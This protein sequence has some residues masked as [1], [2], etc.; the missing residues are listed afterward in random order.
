MHDSL[1]DREV[2]KKILAQE[3]ERVRQALEGKI[4]SMQR[5]ELKAELVS[6]YMLY[7]ALI[8]FH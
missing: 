7:T 2:E 6:L 5:D 8:E 1:T 4:N 3:I